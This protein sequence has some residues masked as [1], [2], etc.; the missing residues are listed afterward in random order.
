M[1][2]K[3]KLKSDML[4]NTIAVFGDPESKE[5]VAL[6]PNK[7]KV[8]WS[9]YASMDEDIDDIE[10]LSVNQNISYQ[11][12]NH[13]LKYYVNDC[14]WYDMNSVRC[15]EAHFTSTDNVFF[16]TPDINITYFTNCLFAKFNSICLENITVDSIQVLD[17]DTNITYDYEDTEGEVPEFLPYQEEFMGPL[18]IYDMPWWHRADISTYDNFALDKKELTEVRKQLEENKD[19]LDADFLTIEEEVRS[20]MNQAGLVSDGEVIDIED[21]KRKRKTWTPKIVK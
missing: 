2:R 20:Q 14:I 19:M 12:I 21:F 3:V 15:V 8:S 6:K 16:I 4:V 10:K 11:R 1:A 17:T 5:V 7:Y 18:S 9:M 13:L